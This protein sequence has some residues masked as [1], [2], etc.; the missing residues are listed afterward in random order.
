MII[1]LIAA[2]SD[3]LVIGKD[4]DLPWRLPPDMKHFRS[5]TIGKPVIMGRKTFGSMNGPLE[6]RQ[7]II[8]TR[9]KDYDVSGCTIAHSLDEALRAAEA[10]PEVMIAGGG[11]I[12]QKMLPRA[13]RMYLTHVH[14]TFEGDTF[15][16]EWD[17]TEWEEYSREDHVDTDYKYDY[18]FVEYRRTN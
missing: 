3:N 5:L 1:S 10:A 12:Y 17:P 11:G 15:F 18:S 13:D 7:N 2:V 8:V 4:N 14:A 6:K 9:Q 16:P